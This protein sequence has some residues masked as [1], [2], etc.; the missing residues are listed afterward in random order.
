MLHTHLSFPSTSFLI[1]SIRQFAVHVNLSITTNVEFQ[2]FRGILYH[3]NTIYWTRDVVIWQK[4]EDVVDRR[5]AID[6]DAAL[7]PPLAMIPDLSAFVSPVFDDTSVGAESLSGGDSLSG[8]EVIISRPLDYTER[9]EWEDALP[10][11]LGNVEEEEAA[12]FQRDS[13][14]L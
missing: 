7:A 12:T 6:W 10:V 2:L 3:K 1:L 9:P 11:G 5:W 13:L 14:H 8:R 4:E